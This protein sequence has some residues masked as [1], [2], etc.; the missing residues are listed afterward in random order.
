MD[1]EDP[2]FE[3]P[4]EREY[5]RALG[6]LAKV[7]SDCALQLEKLQQEVSNLASSLSGSTTGDGDSAASPGLSNGTVGSGNETSV[8]GNK[9][10]LTTVISNFFNSTSSGG[11]TSDECPVCPDP[12]QPKECAPCLECPPPPISDD[13][14][15]TTSRGDLGGISPSFATAEAILVGAA[16]TLIV[17]AL[18]A[19][20]AIILRY[21]ES[22]TSGL[23]IITIIVLV[24]YCSSMYPEAARR[25]GARAWGA[26]RDAAHSIVDR[27]LR[28]HHPE[29]KNSCMG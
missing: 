6:E 27:V 25:L 2:P 8:S 23:L 10:S 16:A 5:S 24:W 28:R 11:R 29:V 18:A 9:T 4:E 3:T 19:A 15:S 26:L 1:P 22:F 12:S 21:L 7:K 14:G 13:C 17:L 20:V